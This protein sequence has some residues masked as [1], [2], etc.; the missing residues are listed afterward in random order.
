MQAD[1]PLERGPCCDSFSG[2]QCQPG[3]HRHPCRRDGGAGGHR[4]PRF[5][6]EAPQVSGMACR[7]DGRDGR[8]PPRRTRSRGDRLVAYLRYLWCRPSRSRRAVLRVRQLH[9]AWVWRRRAGRALAPARPDGGDERRIAVRLVNG[10]H[11]RSA[12]AGHAPSRLGPASPTG[13]SPP[14]E[15]F[16]PHDFL[17]GSASYPAGC[18]D[19]A[20]LRTAVDD[21]AIRVHNLLAT[22]SG[23]VVNPC[24]R[25]SGGS[26]SHGPAGGPAGHAGI[27]HGRRRPSDPRLSLAD[28]RAA[29]AGAVTAPEQNRTARQERERGMGHQ[30]KA[31]W[32]HFAPPGTMP[33][34]I[35]SISL[36]R[37][38]ATPLEPAG[39][40]KVKASGA[41]LTPAFQSLSRSVYCGAAPTALLVMTYLRGTGCSPTSTQICQSVSRLRKA[42][43]SHSTPS[44]TP[45]PMCLASNTPAFSSS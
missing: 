16:R 18:P 5:A 29:G 41:G 32:V 27:A 34:G 38:I 8:G 44:T 19:Q 4:P 15:A 7:S 3:Q 40:L 26:N 43:C 10:S 45:R 30:L 13:R 22:W 33:A 14:P 28:E 25:G 35:S 1:S 6:V 12:A 42:R 17:S 36:S 31:G 39:G 11:L 9:D 2:W 23:I 24:R 20:R 37:V 21:L